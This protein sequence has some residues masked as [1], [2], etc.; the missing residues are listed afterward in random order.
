MWLLSHV[1]VPLKWRPWVTHKRYARDAS[2]IDERPD[3]VAVLPV[4]GILFAPQVFR[5]ADATDDAAHRAHDRRHSSS[6]G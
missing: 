5:T 4:E 2:A 3:G 6:R 1:S